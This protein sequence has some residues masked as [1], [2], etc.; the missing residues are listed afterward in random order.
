MA[1]AEKAVGDKPGS[2][3]H[4]GK[5]DEILVFF[6]AAAEVENFKNID[7][8]NTE[9][10]VKYKSGKNAE[11]GFLRCRMIELAKIFSDT[12]Y[13]QG[14]AEKASHADDDIVWHAVKTGKDR[15]SVV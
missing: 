14:Q 10:I 7:Q 5:V 2:R 12:P 15:K 1:E 11:V 8:I 6:L 9:T 4:G 3:H 13:I